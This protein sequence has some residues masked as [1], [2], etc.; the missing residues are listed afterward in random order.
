MNAIYT[1]VDIMRERISRMRQCVNGA[2]TAC[3]H[4][5]KLI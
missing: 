4:V 3:L 1:H 5:S 2:E